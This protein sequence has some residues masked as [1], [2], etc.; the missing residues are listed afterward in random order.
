KQQMVAILIFLH[1]MKIPVSPASFVIYL[2]WLSTNSPTILDHFA[3]SGV[4]FF[5]RKDC[6]RYCSFEQNSLDG[7]RVSDRRGVP[8]FGGQGGHLRYLPQQAENGGHQREWQP[9]QPLGEG[10]RL[11]SSCASCLLAIATSPL[12]VEAGSVCLVS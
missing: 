11:K 1:A 10:M 9:V 6:C 7:H 5:S 8:S 3:C 4:C 2:C 12:L